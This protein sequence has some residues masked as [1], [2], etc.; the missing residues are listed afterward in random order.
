MPFAV[1]TS[2]G[3]I[4]LT[5]L[6]GS[7]KHIELKNVDFKVAG[8]ALVGTVL[9]SLIASYG[10]IYLYSN[11]STKKLV[12]QYISISLSILLI[13][14]GIKML[15]EKKREGIYKIYLIPK[16]IKIVFGKH[17]KSL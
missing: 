5:A 15:S 16:I 8:I 6:S 2:L 4:T 14:T 7:I 3:Q 12:E 13:V 10:I 1:G 11:A 17:I 9:G